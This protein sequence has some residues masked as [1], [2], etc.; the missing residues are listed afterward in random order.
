MSKASAYVTDLESSSSSSTPANSSWRARRLTKLRALGTREAWL[1][2]YDWGILFR[3][4]LKPWS[5]NTTTI[6]KSETPFYGLE[7]DLPILLAALAGLQHALAMLAGLITPPQILGQALNLPSEQRSYL[8]SASLIACGILSGI[9]MSRI[10]LFKNYQLGTGLLSVVGTSFATLSTAQA[11]IGKMY[12]NGT[13]STIDG[14]KQPCPEAYGAILG[15]SALCSLLPIGLSFVPIRILKR[16]LPPIITGPVVFLIGVSLIQSSGFANWGG[17]AGCGP[18]PR[19]ACFDPHGYQWGSGRYIGLGFL[20][21]LTVVV[22]EIFG[23]PSMRNASIILGLLIPLVVAGPTGYISS[24]SIQA[25]KPITFLWV[26]TFPL[27]IYAPAILPLLAVYLSLVAEAIG[28]ITATS[29]VSRLS[30]TSSSYDRRLQGGILSDGLGGCLSSLFT[31][32]PL[33]VFAQNNGVISLTK[34]A[35]RRAGYWCCTWLILFGIFGKIS[36]A[37]LAIPAPILGGVTTILFASVAI[38][39]LKVL[40]S[41]KFTRRERFLLA[42]SLGIGLGNLL[43]PT[44]FSYLFTYP[45]TGSNTALR[46]FMDSIEIIVETPFLICAVVGMLAN[47]VLPLEIED[48]QQQQLENDIET[49][50]HRDPAVQHQ[51]S[52]SSQTN[53]LPR[54]E[55]GSI[56]PVPN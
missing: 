16:A 6:S 45:E 8:I 33:S 48:R 52:A 54:L 23:S 11:I 1:G 25:A 21:W 28:D 41:I 38:S 2:E 49:G 34:I 44:W 46:G 5:K 42:L 26:H 47:L 30:V 55:K 15:T 32:T 50:Q 17:G 9:Q 31:I 37:V 43:V 56:T 3:L 29:E 18:Q 4:R 27:K 53:N 40:S 14:I 36:G 22:I 51:S 19:G 7:D 35:N 12:A 13:C 10:P 24:S 20:A 39:G